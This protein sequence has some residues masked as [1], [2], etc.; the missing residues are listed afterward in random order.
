[1]GNKFF[2]SIQL[3][4]FISLVFFYKYVV[5]EVFSYMGYFENEFVL[6]KLIIAM[7]TI[8]FC[9]AIH[10][11]TKGTFYK[12]TIQ[13]MM[14]FM[15]V[16]TSVYYIYNGISFAVIVI[17][18]IPIIGLFIMSN[19]NSANPIKRNTIRLNKQNLF[20]AVSV[21]IIIVIPYLFKLDNVNWRNILLEDIYDTRANHSTNLYEGYL[22][23]PL[24]KII[25][26]ILSIIAIDRKNK[27]LLI[28]SLFCICAIFLTTGAQ[29]DMLMGLILIIFCYY[30]VKIKGLG[31]SIK[32]V[33][34]GISILA[35]LGTIL[36][37]TTN[38]LFVSNYLRRL[39]FI[40][41][42]IN[43]MYY[44]YFSE[45]A[46]TLYTHTRF[47][48]LLAEGSRLQLTRWAGEHIIGNGTNANIGIFMEGYISFGFIGVIISAIIFC[49]ICYWI[50]KMNIDKRYIGI[51]VATLYMFNFSLLDILLLTHGLVI[52]LL[53]AY[54]IIPK[55]HNDGGEVIR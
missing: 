44:D 8:L 25:F 42:A 31:N 39:F 33:T 47:G 18:I 5:F 3:F 19:V 51:W 40:G 52:F 14:L 48:S 16:P 9:I 4:F 55:D 32:Y 21:L 10:N 49:C 11:L 22:A 7:L 17:Y 53:A 35:S 6:V 28:F 24:A 34:F 20:F 15:V 41:P 37:I 45:N 29:K 23:N 43:G 12:I 13:G 2:V 54:F 38:N 26:P 50:Y 30:I 46:F 27:I 1:M 36:Y